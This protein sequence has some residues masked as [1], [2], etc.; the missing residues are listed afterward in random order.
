MRPRLRVLASALQD[1]AA[2]RLHR[3][4]GPLQRTERMSYHQGPFGP[5]SAR[6][7]CGATPPS[8]VAARAVKVTCCVVPGNTSM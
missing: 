3:S 7:S 4:P 5:Y 1:S 6:S 8:L 2:S